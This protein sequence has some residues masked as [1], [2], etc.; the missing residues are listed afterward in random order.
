M[1]QLLKNVSDWFGSA[2]MTNKQPQIK[3]TNTTT[4]DWLPAETLSMLGGLH[5]PL[6][7]TF[8]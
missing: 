6:I 7:H 1:T 2:Y 3:S 4:Y 8:G 5:T